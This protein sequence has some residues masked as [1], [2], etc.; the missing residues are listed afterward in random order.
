ME[1]ILVME[2]GLQKKGIATLM[3]V[4]ALEKCDELG[5]TRVLM[6]CNNNVDSAKSI[7]NNKGILENEVMING[8]LYKRYWIEIKERKRNNE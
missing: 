4:L 5:I 1:D 8:I 3:I 2:L 6:V 7:V